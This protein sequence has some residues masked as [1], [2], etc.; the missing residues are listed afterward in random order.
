MA[1]S[2]SGRPSPAVRVEE[3]YAGIREPCPAWRG[4]EPPRQVETSVS[5][6]PPPSHRAVR[7]EQVGQ[8]VARQIDE[9][10]RRIGE[11][12][13]WKAL[14]DKGHE[15]A[16]AQV[17]RRVAELER[18]KLANRGVVVVEAD[19][20]DAVE[21]RDAVGRKLVQI[22]EVIGADAARGAR[23]AGDDD[24]RAPPP[25]PDLEAA[26]VVGEGIRPLG[27]GA[28]VERVRLVVVDEPH[29]HEELLGP[30]RPIIRVGDLA[31]V[32]LVAGVRTVSAPVAAVAVRD[33][34]AEAVARLA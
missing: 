7:L 6:V 32:Q 29:R 25:R 30:L 14:P 4:C 5:E 15:P 13:A 31:Q 3:L 24:P 12:N 28:A 11:R 8:P 33:S 16:L 23:V 1:T 22:D 27:L 10:D 34:V 20:L 19:R 17:E 21:Q 18:R 2:R 26:P 9:L